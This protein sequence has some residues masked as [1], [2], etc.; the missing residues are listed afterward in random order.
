[1]GTVITPA[2]VAHIA[3]LAN[4][5]VSAQEQGAF[6]AAF[7]AT[8]DEVAKLSELATG[9]VN[10]TNHVTGLQNVWREDQVDAGRLL[11][12]GDVIGQS[13]H[14]LRGYVVV[15]RVLED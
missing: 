6:A 7:S 15:D 5:Q 12:H 1:M 4:L 3:L 8:L 10:P 14:V 11:S 9:S 13:A 2:T